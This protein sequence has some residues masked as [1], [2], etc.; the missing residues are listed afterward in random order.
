MNFIEDWN[1]TDSNTIA[2][3]CGLRLS[4]EGSMSD[5][6]GVIVDSVPMGITTLEL[7]ALIREGT[8]YCRLKSNQDLVAK[9][10]NNAPPSAAIDL[11]GV[12]LQ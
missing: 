1:A 5:P 6:Q 12:G 7:V 11:A 9:I 4:I 8:V 2:H 10:A 3:V